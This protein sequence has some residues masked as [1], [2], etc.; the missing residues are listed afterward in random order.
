MTQVDCVES[1]LY[2]KIFLGFYT[3]VSE[4]RA[5]SAEKFWK[6]EVYIEPS[7]IWTPQATTSPLLG[8][9]VELECEAEGNPKPEIIW[10]KDGS[11]ITEANNNRVSLS[12]SRLV[13][14]NLVESDNGSYKCKAKNA[15]GSKEYS[16]V[17][18][19]NSPPSISIGSRQI[20][21]LV[22]EQVEIICEVN[23]YPEPDII[24]SKDGAL[25]PAEKLEQIQTERNSLYFSAVTVDDAGIY[26]CMAKV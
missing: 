9:A 13:I 2:C 1:A 11:I 19:V 10:F 6:I 7:F 25:I 4:N 20:A 8:E 14:R 21:S 22:N 3:C 23:G 24:W 15:A 12:Q 16:T 5:G 17:L 26:T 18:K